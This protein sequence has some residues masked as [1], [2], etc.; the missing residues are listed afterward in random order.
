M[1]QG[2]PGELKQFMV[3]WIDQYLTQDNPRETN[4]FV[5]KNDLNNDGNAF[6]PEDWHKKD[7]WYRSKVGESRANASLPGRSVVDTQTEMDETSTQVGSDS[8][9]DSSPS[10]D[11]DSPEEQESGPFRIHSLDDPTPRYPSE[12]LSKEAWMEFFELFLQ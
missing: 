5:Y 6:S 12:R 10:S 11:E 1:R 4:E 9:T 8:D 7:G 3:S 2:S